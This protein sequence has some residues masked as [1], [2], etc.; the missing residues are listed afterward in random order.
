MRDV[1]GAPSG[2]DANGSKDASSS[3]VAVNCA[4]FPALPSRPKVGDGVIPKPV[5]FAGVV[6]ANAHK[7]QTNAAAFTTAAQQSR[8]PPGSAAASITCL[9]VL[10][11]GGVDDPAKEALLRTQTDKIVMQVRNS[12]QSVVSLSPFH[13]LSGNWARRTSLGS[14]PVP[15]GNFTFTIAG[16][17]DFQAVLPFARHFIAPLLKGVLYP[18]DKWA[19]AQLRG[20]PTKS[21][22]GV[23]Y[24]GPELLAE[25]QRDPVLGP[26]QLVNAPHWQGK[27]ANLADKEKLTV[28]IAFV[29]PC[30]SASAALAKAVV[31]M[32]GARTPVLVMGESPVIH[33]CSRCHE[34]GHTTATCRK[35]AGFLRCYKCGGAHLATAHGAVCKGPHEKPGVCQC[36]YPCLLC[37]KRGHHA[38]DRSCPKQ[39]RLAPPPLE[40]TGAVQCPVDPLAPTPAP[41]APAVPRALVRAPADAPAAPSPPA[42]PVPPQTV[43]PPPAATPAIPL[44]PPQVDTATPY[45][46]SRPQLPFT[47]V[48]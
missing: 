45:S 20:V 46:P 14:K 38:R 34:L 24:D 4:A 15:T 25:L 48:T 40:S 44:T 10:R 28:C 13:V 6:T 35:P 32:F 19:Y 37:G 9:V 36:R 18:G 43:P 26:L 21:P 33:Q 47:L 11:D 1:G 39:G 27:V 12:I 3:T 17:V 31:S 41:V 8:P 5:T 16:T 29:D 23:V 2:V 30:G 42:P 7:N 22:S